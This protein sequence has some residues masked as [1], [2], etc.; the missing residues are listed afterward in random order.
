MRFMLLAWGN[1]TFLYIIFLI[2]FVFLERN[3]KNMTVMYWDRDILIVYSPTKYLHFLLQRWVSFKLRIHIV[4]SMPWISSKRVD[5]DPSDLIRQGRWSQQGYKAGCPIW[6]GRARLIWRCYQIT[7][8]RPA[9]DRARD[10]SGV[11][12]M[13]ARSGRCFST[14][15]GGGILTR[16]CG[17]E[18]GY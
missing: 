9:P 14:R 3:N 1:S 2:S 4:G 12:R 16:G 13:A 6:L 11:G 17:F 5:A 7:T 18:S 10:K 15:S 8:G